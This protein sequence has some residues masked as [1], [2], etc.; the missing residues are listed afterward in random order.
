MQSIQ[1]KLTWVSDVASS[2]QTK[3]VLCPSIVRRILSSG[4]KVSSF[5]RQAKSSSWR[6]SQGLSRSLVG[7]WHMGGI[8][9]N[10]TL[11]LS[12][13]IRRGL[14]E[15]EQFHGFPLSFRPWRFCSG[16]KDSACQAR[17]TVLFRA[18]ST[19]IAVLEC[20]N[21]SSSLHPSRPIL[22]LHTHTQTPTVFIH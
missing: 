13:H 12:I 1:K 14:R 22:Q 8:P 17:N 9:S 6:R 19:A 20:N 2:R 15:H 16:K 21:N 4:A 11:F 10:G 5:G 3:V 18:K 7:S